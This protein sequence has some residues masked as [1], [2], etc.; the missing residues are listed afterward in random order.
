QAA[1]AELVEVTATVLIPKRRLDERHY[2][3]YFEEPF[4]FLDHQFLPASPAQ[5]PFFE[6]LT[7]APQHGLSLIHRLVDHAISFY[8]RGRGYGGDTITISFPAGER[9]FP[10]K[11]SY[12]WSR[13]GAGHYSVTSALMA[14]EAWA[15]RRIEAG[16]TFDMVL[17]KKSMGSRL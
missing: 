5:G 10:W 8:S 11:R 17:A 4:D 15:H 12:V 6:L 9:A 13:E 7:H 3:R 16:E 14:L 1:P 2:R